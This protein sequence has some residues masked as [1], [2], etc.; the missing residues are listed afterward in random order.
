MMLRQA[1]FKRVGNWA[2]LSSCAR[3]DLLHGKVVPTPRWHSAPFS[4]STPLQYEF[5]K[6]EKRG[7][8]ENVALVRLNRP[9]ALNALC[10][11]LMR[12]LGEAVKEFDADGGVGAIVITGS[13]KAFAAGADIAEMQ[14]STYMDCYMRNFLS[15]SIHVHPHTHTH[16]HTHTYTH[17]HYLSSLTTITYSFIL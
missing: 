17:T 1:V 5:I 9:R 11:Q 14:N 15:K 2:A 8:K 4:T 3:R 13:D 12:E 7:E 10:D 16:T 6:T